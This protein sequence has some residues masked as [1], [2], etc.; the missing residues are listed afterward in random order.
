MSDID[1]VMKTVFDEDYLQAIEVASFQDLWCWDSLKYLQLVL[2]IQ[3]TFKIELSQ[4]EIQQL[5]SFS[6]VKKILEIHGI[7]D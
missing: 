6:N 7:T 5:T 3:A 4:T 2:N 1:Q